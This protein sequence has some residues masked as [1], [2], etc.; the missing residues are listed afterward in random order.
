MCCILSLEA[1]HADAYKAFQMSR[2]LETVV[3]CFLTNLE[4]KPSALGSSL[5]RNKVVISLMTP[6]LPMLVYQNKS[7]RI[8]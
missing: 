5:S 2:D 8:M 3:R 7:A 1:V 4:E 6:V